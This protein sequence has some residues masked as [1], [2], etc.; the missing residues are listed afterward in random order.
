MLSSTAVFWLFSMKA[1]RLLAVLLSMAECA[2]LQ[3]GA[4]LAITN[5]SLSARV[6]SIVAWSTSCTALTGTWC[7]LAVPSVSSRCT[8]AT[9]VSE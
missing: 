9:T 2:L 1:S 5:V 8:S 3:P 4:E 6:V 7:P